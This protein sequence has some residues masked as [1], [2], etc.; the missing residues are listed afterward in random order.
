MDEHKHTFRKELKEFF[1][2]LGNVVISYTP[3]S[4]FIDTFRFMHKWIVKKDTS[5]RLVHHIKRH[6]KKMQLKHRKV[7]N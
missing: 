5:R 4:G 2:D 1:K 7:Y 6:K 3:V